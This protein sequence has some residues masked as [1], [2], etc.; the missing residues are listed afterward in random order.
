MPAAS[1]LPRSC[2]KPPSLPRICQ[3]SEYHCG[4]AVLQMLLAQHG[5]VA[6]QERLT[7]LADVA[8]TIGEYGTRVD[9]LA[10]AVAWLREGVRLWYKTH[11]TADDLTALVCGHRCPA[12]VEWQGCFEDSEAEEDFS[13]GDY[14]HYSVVISVDR[15]RELITLRDPYPEFC[16]TDRVFSLSW[17]IGRWWDVNLKPNPKTGRLRPVEDRRMLFVI[18]GKRARFPEQL[19]MTQG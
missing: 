17:F 15:R 13:E 7:D 18:T 5:V 2:R 14:G 10:R 9:Q 4:P 1:T 16:R 3:I 8:K 11:A 6:S 19:G 12:G